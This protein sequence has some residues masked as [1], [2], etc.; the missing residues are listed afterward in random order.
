M[1]TPVIKNYSAYRT[2]AYGMNHYYF[3]CPDCV[4]HI[5]QESALINRLNVEHIRC[6]V[7]TALTEVSLED[8]LAVATNVINA[9]GFDYFL[10][11]PLASIRN[12]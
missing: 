4:I 8:Y 7:E 2:N 12:N 5:N 10:N 3:Q 1:E 6:G 11:A 9:L